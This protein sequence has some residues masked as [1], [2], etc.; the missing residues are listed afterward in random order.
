[1]RPRLYRSREDYWIAGVCG[2][3]GRY[4]GVD[5]NPIRLGFVV[6]AA[7]NGLG[8]LL[9]LVT[10]LIVP[11]EPADEAATG[12]GGPPP[13]ASARPAVPHESRRVRMLGWLLIL[14]GAY[15]LLRNLHLFIPIVQ[16]Q[17]F[18][19]LLILGGL[20]LLLMRTESRR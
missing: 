10:V 6:L 16:D 18:P 7:W 15:L 5:S 4:F 9:Y 20:V 13:P 2:G 14:G 12:A 1:M 3:L 8:V 19:V 17:V 11:E